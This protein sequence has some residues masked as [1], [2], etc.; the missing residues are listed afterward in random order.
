[1]A[2]P[3]PTDFVGTEDDYKAEDNQPAKTAG[4]EPHED[5]WKYADLDAPHSPPTNEVE[6][7]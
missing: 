5:P 1:M 6:D 4:E 2:Q 3:D 7:E